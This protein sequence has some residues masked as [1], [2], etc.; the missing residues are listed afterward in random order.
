MDLI[1]PSKFPLESDNGLLSAKSQVIGNACRP[2]VF[3]ACSRRLAHAHNDELRSATLSIAN[4]K[5]TPNASAYAVAPA[6][7]FSRGSSSGRPAANA[8]ALILAMASSTRSE[9]VVSATSWRGVKRSPY[10]VRP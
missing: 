9:K 8:S 6:P 5:Y 10:F 2:K 1:P 7:S 3:L 4:A